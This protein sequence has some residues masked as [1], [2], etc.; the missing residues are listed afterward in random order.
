MDAE[1]TNDVRF[2]LESTYPSER[3]SSKGEDVDFA[4]SACPL[5]LIAIFW[6]KDFRRN[7]YVLPIWP[8]SAQ[9]TNLQ[10]S[11]NGLGVS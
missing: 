3:P 9:L 8:M 11:Q 5:C 4:A 7:R 6:R 1:A 10:D 2:Y